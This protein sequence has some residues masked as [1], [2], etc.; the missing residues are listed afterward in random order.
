MQ[1]ICTQVAGFDAEWNEVAAAIGPRC[2]FPSL[3]PQYMSCAI[4]ITGA[5]DEEENSNDFPG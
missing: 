5:C 4:C 2:S 3:F 1:G